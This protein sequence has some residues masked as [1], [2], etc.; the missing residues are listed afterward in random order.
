MADPR[1]TERREQRIAKE[2][3]RLI[4]LEHKRYLYRL[5]GNSLAEKREHS[6]GLSRVDVPAPLLQNPPV[7]VN[8]KSWSGPWV[9][10]TDPKDIEKFVCTINQK[11]YNQAYGTPFALGYLAQNIG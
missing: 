1:N 2:V 10:V 9:S 5:I 8:P 4:R 6:Y 7:P 11:Q 3:K